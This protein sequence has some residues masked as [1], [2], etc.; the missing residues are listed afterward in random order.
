VR[1]SA[2]YNKI[3]WYSFFFSLLVIWIHA[4]NAELFLGSGAEAS[5]AGMAENFLGERIGQIAVPGFFMISGYL[6][7][8]DFE[9]AKLRSKWTRRIYSVLVPYIAWNVIYYA[10][11]VIGSRLPWMNRVV[12]KGVI[13]L[14]LAELTEAILHFKYNPV[15]WYMYQLIFLILLAPVLYVVLKQAWAAVIW[16]VVLAWMLVTGAELPVINTDALMYYSA[17]AEAALIVAKARAQEDVS[18]VK[19]ISRKKAH[20]K[21]WLVTGACMIVSAI[22]VYE[23]GLIL[24]APACFVLC[25]LLAVGGLWLL[26]P[27]GMLPPATDIMRN[28]FFLYATHFAFVRLINKSAAM[29]LPHDPLVPLLLYLAM[30]GIVLGISVVADKWLRTCFP[31]LGVILNGGR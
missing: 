25:R 19:A 20:E 15:F 3:T 9:W 1:D 24:A 27:G 11:Y 7:F 2:F 6:F 5:F 21:M 23:T 10:G 12:G 28:Y 30:P 17:A 16:F 29:L 13:P 18:G 26:I 31:G 8:I 14:S 22:V 4:Y